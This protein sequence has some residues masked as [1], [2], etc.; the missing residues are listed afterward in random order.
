MRQKYLIKTVKVLTQMTKQ[1][2]Q[3]LIVIVIFA[4]NTKHTNV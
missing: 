2:K 3:K 1:K 4:G